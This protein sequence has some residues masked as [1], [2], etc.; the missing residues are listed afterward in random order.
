MARS[1]EIQGPSSLLFTKPEADMDQTL[2]SLHPLNST[3]KEGG[4]VMV[5][6]YICI[7]HESTRTWLHVDRGSMTFG[8]QSAVSS[9]LIDLTKLKI[10][11]R[12]KLFDEDAF[13]V[14]IADKS[15]IEDV[16]YSKSQISY[17]NKQIFNLT[18]GER[19]GF[20]LAS[21]VVTTSSAAFTT[22]RVIEILSDLII[23]CTISGDMNPF[24]REGIPIKE[25]QS[26]LC[27]QNL[28]DALVKL[29]KVTLSHSHLSSINDIYKP[30]NYTT[31]T[32]CR[33]SYRLLRQ[34]IKD[35]PSNQ[36]SMSSMEYIKFM[37]EMIH[38]P[39]AIA[40]LMELFR[41][42]KKLLDKIT[43]DQ[44]V[45]FVKL[46]KELGMDSNF[47][48]FLSILCECDGVA[49]ARNQ[50][51]VCEKL[52]V[53]NP[54]LLIGIK[55]VNETILVKPPEHKEWMNI[56]QFVA[57]SNPNL[58]NYFVDTIK[59]LSDLCKGRNVDTCS[60]ISTVMTYDLVFLCVSNSNLPP[61]LRTAFTELLLHLY[62]DVEPF[63]KQTFVNFTRVW[64]DLG[65]KALTSKKGA[66]ELTV[67]NSNFELLKTFIFDYLTEQRIQVVSK[68][69]FNSLSLSVCLSFSLLT[70]L[71]L[72]LSLS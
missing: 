28:I 12:S 14:N 56:E 15:E 22:K 34:V 13:S 30:D 10:E 8:A 44:I 52:V 37:E 65:K 5:E 50:L 54:N 58:L 51:L 48:R 69:S 71:S 2:F 72:E 19:A 46:L 3:K 62:I 45:F 66:Y 40:T 60:A 31:Y 68:T 26:L 49:N 63:E 33:L 70:S 1:G 61:E 20:T 6:N 16:Y 18:K 36:L 67:K 42:N 7:K 27:E 21:L 53:E 55:K 9:P 47:V 32:I 38:F 59:L 64:S 4:K 39:E 11:G 25:R 43:V 17:I 24:T 57:I 35:N 41:N 23:S 29:V